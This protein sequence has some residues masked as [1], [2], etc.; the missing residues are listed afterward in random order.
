MWY[1]STL[2][3][4]NDIRSDM[5]YLIARVRIALLFGRYLDF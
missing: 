5:K 3:Q 1:K 2:D 4:F